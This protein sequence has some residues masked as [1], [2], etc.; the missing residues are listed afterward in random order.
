[1]IVAVRLVDLSLQYRLH[2]PRLNA[3]RRQT[4]LGESAQQ[5]LRQR[6]SFQ[7]NSLEVVGRALQHRRQCFG[8]TRH[9]YFPN[10]L[11]RVIHNADTRVRIFGWLGKEWWPV[12]ASLLQSTLVPPDMRRYDAVGLIV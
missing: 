7:S 2:V 6:P 8:F 9:L 10:D 1:R 5:P 11:A 4:R 3:D 12:G